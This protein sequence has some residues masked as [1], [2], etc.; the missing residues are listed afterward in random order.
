MPDRKFY[1]PRVDT[2]VKQPSPFMRYDAEHTLT[3][4]YSV[5]KA[6]GKPGWD[7]VGVVHGPMS[8]GGRLVKRAL[9]PETRDGRTNLT[10][11]TRKDAYAAIA[12][13]LS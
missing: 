12:E 4:P 9:S 2:I 13:F 1:D 3:G 6:L 11:K 5:T 8:Y 7:V 10:F